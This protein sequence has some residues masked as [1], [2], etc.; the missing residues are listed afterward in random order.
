[1]ILNI[2]NDLSV[3]LILPLL[4]FVDD[5]LGLVVDHQG[6]FSCGL[7]INL[8]NIDFDLD[9]LGVLFLTLSHLVLDVFIDQVIGVVKSVV[10]E[11]QDAVYHFL[12]SV[13]FLFCPNWLGESGRYELD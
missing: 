12:G 2:E 13:W 6:L 11:V 8:I 4:I 10:V 9:V 1:M 7:G 5:L 3:D